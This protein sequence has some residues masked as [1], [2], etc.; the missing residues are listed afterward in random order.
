MVAV[1]EHTKV[2]KFRI[3][4]VVVLS[5]FIIF[6]VLTNTAQAFDYTENPSHEFP[7]P[8]NL[9]ILETLG[10]YTDLSTND[11]GNFTHYWIGFE[12]YLENY[13]IEIENYTYD[14]FGQRIKT[15]RNDTAQTK[16]YTPFKE[17]MRIVNSSGGISL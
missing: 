5:A 11:S 16:I 4:T 12:I 10:T 6:L 14:P 1:L 3:N 2:V 8:I 13:S 15:E 7:F 17:L 9:T